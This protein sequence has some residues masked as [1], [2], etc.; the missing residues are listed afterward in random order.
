MHNNLYTYFSASERA[1][2]FISLTGWAVSARR[3]YITYTRETWETRAALAHK[4][5][6]NRET[7]IIRASS[8]IYLFLL[9]FIVLVFSLFW[10]RRLLS[11]WSIS[12]FSFFLFF[13][14]SRFS[15]S[16]KKRRFKV[17]TPVHRFG[18]RALALNAILETAKRNVQI[19]F[20]RRFV[21]RA[22][23]TN[24]S[25]VAHEMKEKAAAVN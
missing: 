23:F 5:A 16:K 3:A 7:N 1:R 14:S 9:L 21:F 22:L 11:P 25:P 18:D 20:F 8:F 2:A 24:E 6:R 4:T 10:A 17:T 15:L 12:S 13:F 19:I